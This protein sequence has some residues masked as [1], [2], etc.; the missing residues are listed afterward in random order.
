MAERAAGAEFAAH[1]RV[2]AASS[3]GMGVGLTMFSFIQSIFVS[4]MQRAFGWSR[5]DMAFAMAGLLIGALTAP[6]LGM[7]IDRYGVRP[8]VLVSMTCSGLCFALLA[9][10]NA[11]I[12]TYYLA[13]NLLIVLGSGT[14]PISYARAVSSWF[15]KGLGLALAVALSGV[16][17]TAFLLP[18]LLTAVIAA[19]G[20]R[21]GYLF[22][23]LL[24]LL[25][26]VPI[27][28]F[29]LFERAAPDKHAPRPAET[30]VSAAQALRDRRFWIMALAV[31]L[32]T[33]PAISLSSQLQPLLT[34]KGFS[35]ATAANLLSL[36]A[37]S[38]LAGRIVIGQLFDRFWAPGVACA[39][40][41]VASGGAFLLIGPGGSFGV[42]AL[43]LMLLG[44]AQGAEINLLAFLIARY[45]GTRSFSAIYGNLNVVFGL[46][47]AAGAVMFG[48]LYD[49][50]GNYD[51]GLR[52]AGWFL[53]GSAALF[54]LMGRYPEWEA[55]TDDG[56]GG[57]LS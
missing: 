23:A 39:T 26:G 22:L 31:T 1:W 15:D 5:G 53:L 55:A 2:V 27:T 46:S 25:I 21:A 6:L 35:P 8:V 56:P 43:S 49:T 30:G 42:C 47:I 32:V 16:S 17:V 3:L 13:F 33:V 34:D 9:A 41:A 57:D 45:F 54:P 20:W 44:I 28:W 11:H 48:K 50:Y 4:E 7:L 14:T 36:F 18:P 10:I 52:I 51:L 24:P 29:W 37:L 19:Y 40:L 12:W 38:V